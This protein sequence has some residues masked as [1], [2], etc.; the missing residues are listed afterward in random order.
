MLWILNVVGSTQYLFGLL[1]GVLDFAGHEQRGERRI[2]VVVLGIA[3]AE[4]EK[5]IVSASGGECLDR[6][7][8]P[9]LEH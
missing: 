8:V 3:M 9:P 2:L 1:D 4:P 7:V 6:S 5:V